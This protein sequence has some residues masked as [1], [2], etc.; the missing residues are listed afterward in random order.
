MSRGLFISFEGVEGC[1]KSTQLRLL[2]EYL[3]AQGRDCVV[4]REPG[5]VPIAEAIRE[6]LLNP[7][8]EAMTPEAELLLYAAARAQHV[9]EKIVPAL[10]A[11]KVVLCD[12]F[13]DSTTA[14]QGGGRGFDTARLAQLHG[15]ATGGRWPD[16]TLL[17]DLDAEAGLERA[18]QRGRRDRI[19]RE[20]IAFHQRVRQAYLDLAVLEPER[21]KVVSASG[22]IEEIHQQIRGLVDELIQP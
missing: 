19:E 2:E 18:R 4:T 12:R 15:W 11:G 22:S 17:L 6:L 16:R 21:I 8:H 3:R 14:Y 7:D 13:A 20:D 9:G 5:G 10:E 1:G